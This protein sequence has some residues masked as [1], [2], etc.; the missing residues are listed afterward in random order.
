MSR[1]FPTVMNKAISFLQL[2]FLP[3]SVDA[4]LLVLRLGLGLSLF[5]LH[6]LGKA[7]KF[8]EL[9]QKF[10]DPLGIGHPA[11]ATLA[12]FAETI[13]ALLLALGLFTRFAALNIAVTMAVAF[14]L[15]H[16]FALSGEYSGELAYLYLL[17]SVPLFIAGPGRFSL[18]AMLNRSTTAAPTDYR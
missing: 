12:V 8:S 10:P 17:A 7:M 5:W 1:Q 14:S 6:G 13:C 9:L 15:V 16:K 2:N 11:S 4:G 3:R 18:D